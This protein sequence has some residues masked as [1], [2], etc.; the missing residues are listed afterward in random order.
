MSN[1]SSSTET[2]PLT[3]IHVNVQRTKLV[4]L[5]DA[6]ATCQEILRI[7]EQLHWSPHCLSKHFI[8]DRLIQ[9]KV[10]SWESEVTPSA[11]PF[12]KRFCKINHSR[13]QDYKLPGLLCQLIAKSKN[14]PFKVN[15]LCQKSSE[16]LWIYL[17]TC[18][19]K[20]G[21]FKRKKYCNLL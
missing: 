7:K 16:S 9:W 14:W 8:M 1:N 13:L 5:L 15:F 18:T 21:C 2:M 10:V 17:R 20:W 11:I 19:S 12:F 3:T 6:N 4:N